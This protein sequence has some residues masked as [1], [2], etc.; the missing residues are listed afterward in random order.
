MCGG[1]G[2]GTYVGREDVV[3]EEGE[4]LHEVGVFVQV[5]EAQFRPTLDELDYPGV[6]TI[7]TTIF[8]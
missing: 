7:H 4:L 8:A 3:D 6:R 5:V 1:R 2:R